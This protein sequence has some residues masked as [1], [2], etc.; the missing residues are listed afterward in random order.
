MKNIDDRPAGP[1]VRWNPV[2]PPDEDMTSVSATLSTQ[3]ILEA[4]ADLA[5]TSEAPA[6]SHRGDARAAE[7]ASDKALGLAPPA[8]VRLPVSTAVLDRMSQSM[9]GLRELARFANGPRY[10]AY[11]TGGKA[12]QVTKLG[13]LSSVQHDGKKITETAK[14]RSLR[15]GQLANLGFSALTVVVGMEHMA[16]IDRQLRILNEKT[17][18]IAAMLVDELTAPIRDV[19]ASIHRFK[20]EGPDG[21]PRAVAE[22]WVRELRQV[23][24]RLV[25]K[26][27]RVSPTIAPSKSF[28]WSN[29]V[30][31]LKA[32]AIKMADAGRLIQMLALTDTFLHRIAESV[33]LPMA[34]DGVND[35]DAIR[36]AGDVNTAT[37]A[38]MS[39][40]DKDCGY[41]NTGKRALERR[42]ALGNA[43][44]DFQTMVLGIKEA[45][46]MRLLGARLNDPDREF[47]VTVEDDRI[48]SIHEVKIEAVPFA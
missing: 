44:S 6:P 13:K 22:A 21:I 3:A 25:S 2:S 17:E 19:A 43:Q 11:F 1:T 37:K 33:E 23:R 36:L 29:Q 42:N 20:P 32:G 46:N 31:D 16:R 4:T 41:D 18:E 12:A 34:I 26:I 47:R 24:Y 15:P 28:L 10:E 27:A 45:R 7:V 8:V 5:P 48:V 38:L 40:T 30:S 35:R 39:S 9:P 14:L